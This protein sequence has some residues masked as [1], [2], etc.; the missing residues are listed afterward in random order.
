MAPSYPALLAIV[1]RSYF[2]DNRMAGIR[3]D[4]RHYRLIYTQ[5][6]FTSHRLEM[7][8]L[9][10]CQAGI[11]SRYLTKSDLFAS[12]SLSGAEIRTLWFLELK[13][14]YSMP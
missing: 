6:P 13:F 3:R 4:N 8:D 5:T 11:E 10:I 9:V 1:P 14:C 12:S 2:K 7:Y